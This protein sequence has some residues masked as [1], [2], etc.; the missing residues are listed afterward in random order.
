MKELKRCPFCGGPAEIIMVT[1]HID[2]NLIVVR[3]TRC[4][5]STKTFSEHKPEYAIEAWNV[6]VG[7]G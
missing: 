5:A 1:R 6:R 4:M 3:C 2:N 7:N